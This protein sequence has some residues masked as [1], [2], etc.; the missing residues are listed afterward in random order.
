MSSSFL[1]RTILTL[2]CCALPAVGWAQIND[3]IY[4]QGGTPTRGDIAGS[5]PDE[6]EVV[7]A[8][9]SQKIP[10]NKIRKINFGGEPNELRTARDHAAQGRYEDAI[11]VL[12]KVNAS[13]IK[14]PLIQQD[15]QYIKAFSQAKLA[16]TGG[17]DKKAAEDTLLK[18]FARYNK[19][20]YHAYECAEI[21]GDLAV[22]NQDFEEAGKRYGYLAKAPWKDYQMRS[23]VLQASAM[24]GQGKYAEAKT[25][26]DD[27]VASPLD[28]PAAQ[29]QK[30]QAMVGQALCLA[31][32]G[33]PAAGIKLVQQVIGSN[34]PQ[35]NPALFGRAYNS[36]GRC[37]LKSNKPKDALL[38]YLH[39]DVL[40][41][42]DPETHAEAL[43]YLTKLWTDVKKSERA[44]QSRTLLQS[45]Y[46]G[47]SWAKK[48]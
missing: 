22:A 42:Q 17:G 29:E 35:Q 8:G 16:L 36:L 19:S 15:Y 34:E 7:V 31:E 37:Y 43:Y 45:R 10:T 23:S 40:F 21:L 1:S 38:A 11:E 32:T 3:Q 26:F 24:L 9:A 6:V 30:R 28:D 4:Q 39:V 48:S 12:D 18:F 41:Y 5:T 13:T 25:K 33:D 14:R 2:A 47:S 20:T 27:V 44:I 46:A